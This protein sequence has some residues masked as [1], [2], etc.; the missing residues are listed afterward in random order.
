MHLTDD[1]I[2]RAYDNSLWS[3]VENVDTSYDL[4]G[5]TVYSEQINL[6]KVPFPPECEN[7][8]INISELR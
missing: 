3:V 8:D 1:Q 2:K 7:I 4:K 5:S 6:S